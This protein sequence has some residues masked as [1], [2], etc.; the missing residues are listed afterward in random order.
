[1][2]NPLP[3]FFQFERP[4]HLEATMFGGGF[5]SDKYGTTQ[6]GFQLEQSLT[7]YIGAFGRVSGYQL[8]IGNGFESPLNPTA[9]P[10]SR[11][12]FGRLQGGIDFAP[13]QGTH[14]FI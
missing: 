7:R 5:G 8:W 4:G 11:L 3:D 2:N 13:I 6:E 1:M 10:H 12:N 14:L 9:G